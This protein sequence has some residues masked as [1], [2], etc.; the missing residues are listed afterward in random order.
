MRTLILAGSFREASDYARARGL[1]HYRF[2]SSAAA[3]E[4]FQ[5]QAVVELPGYARRADK[6]ALNAIANRAVR[7]GAK[8][9]KDEHVLP[10]APEPTMTEKARLADYKFGDV[11][12]TEAFTELEQAASRRISAEPVKVSPA[13]KA[14]LAKKAAK[15]AADDPFEA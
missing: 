15:S 5:A 3:V 9:T 12:V 13:T 6:H 11:P 2:A 4:H 10:P 14:R 8:W 1:R 7:R